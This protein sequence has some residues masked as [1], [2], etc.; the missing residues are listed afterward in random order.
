MI[1]TINTIIL[2]E[3]DKDFQRGFKVGYSM[4]RHHNINVDLKTSFPV[5][6]IHLIPRSQIHGQLPLQLCPVRCPL[7]HPIPSAFP[8]QKGQRIAT[9]YITHRTGNPH[10]RH[11]LRRP[12]QRTNHR[13]IKKHHRREM[14]SHQKIT[15]HPLRAYFGAYEDLPKQAD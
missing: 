4:L 6:R 12:R 15:N 14:L 2:F 7:I 11:E 5:V 3:S 9:P 8:L 1:F 13:S 10:Q